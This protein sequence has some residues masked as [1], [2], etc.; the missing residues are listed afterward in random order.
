MSKRV[1]REEE[2][3]TRNKKNKTGSSDDAKS[4]EEMLMEDVYM[5]DNY[6]FGFSV[7]D[8]NKPPPKLNIDY[9]K[10]IPENLSDNARAFYS[11]MVGSKLWNYADENFI[12]DFNISDYQTNE[13][14]DETDIES[15][16]YNW[17]IFQ[18][19]MGIKAYGL[20]KTFMKITEFKEECEPD[21]VFRQLIN[22]PTNCISHDEL[23]TWHIDCC[24]KEDVVFAL[25]RKY[26]K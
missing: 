11:K 12:S 2:E 18:I 14:L 8:I 22:I 6:P 10:P 20:L 23:E 25:L 3:N 5:I 13:E 7:E 24:G 21:C 16:M 17:N 15:E 19:L 9:T 1:M 26:R 4:F